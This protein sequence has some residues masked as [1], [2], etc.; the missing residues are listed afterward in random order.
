MAGLKARRGFNASKIQKGGLKQSISL[1]DSD[2]AWGYCLSCKNVLPGVQGSP[3]SQS[4]SP[5]VQ[6][7]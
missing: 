2:S 6:V 5:G 1:W 3:L 7:N 4:V